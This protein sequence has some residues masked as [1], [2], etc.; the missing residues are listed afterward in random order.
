MDRPVTQIHG[1]EVDRDFAAFIR[2]QV[3]PGTNVTEDAFWQ[4]YA[5]LLDGFADENRALLDRRADL[6]GR[7][8]AWHKARGNQPWDGAEYRAFLEGI[9]YLTPEPAPFTID[10]GAIDPEIAT[11][12]GPQ[13]VVPVSNARFALNAANARWGSLYD[14]LYGSDV[15]GPVPSGGFDTARRDAVVARAAQFLDQAV[16]LLAGS[17]AAVEAYGADDQGLIATIAGQPVRLADA[18][19]YVGTRT[20]GADTAHVLRHHGLHVELV[21]NSGDP[22]GAASTSGLRDV[23]LE[24]ALSAIQDCEDSVAAVD[25]PDKIGV[26]A[27]WLVPVSTRS[28]AARKAGPS[29]PGAMGR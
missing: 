12:A 19:T 16:P 3:L 11:M 6:Q 18:D 21:I 2:T 14:A 1:L 27:S 10:N 26:Y 15:M 7:I 29:K 28:R 8:D 24:A 20:E 9:G 13:L 5:S 4:G 22:I 17:H 23:V 25:A